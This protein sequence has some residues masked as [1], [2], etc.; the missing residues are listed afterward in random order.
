MD[1]LVDLFSEPGETI[2][3]AFGGSGTTAVAA[4]RLGRKCIVIEQTEAHCESIVTRLS[5][6]SFD[7]ESLQAI[8]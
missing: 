8:S 1:K 7:L 2:L 6:Q 5:Q 4:K 3:D